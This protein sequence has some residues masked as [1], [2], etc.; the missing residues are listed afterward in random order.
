VYVPA[1]E[2]Y[3]RG[4]FQPPQAVLPQG[5]GELI[6]VVDDEAAIRDILKLT[7]ENNGYEVI[8]AAE[9]TEA[10]A[11]LAAEK[12]EISAVVVDL[13]MPIMDGI[14]TMRALQKLNPRVKFL[15][16]SGLMDHAR[17]SQLNEVAHAAFLAKP[18]TTEELLNRLH[19][20]LQ[21]SCAG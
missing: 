6:M 13:M 2:S 21:E 19:A 17:I 3:F 15:A 11:G 1:A 14:A 5:K 20:M 10:V 8:T 7:L 12:R 4:E 18:F 16:I 9:G